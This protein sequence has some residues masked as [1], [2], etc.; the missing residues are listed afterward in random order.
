MKYIGKR[1]VGRVGTTCGDIIYQGRGYTADLTGFADDIDYRTHTHRPTLYKY[2]WRNVTLIK[3]PGPWAAVAS[4]AVSRHP[5][6]T[7][8]AI[9]TTPINY[10]NNNK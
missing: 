6:E 3:A 7:L 9:Y 10:N 4:A 8:L 2:S 1:R 5:S